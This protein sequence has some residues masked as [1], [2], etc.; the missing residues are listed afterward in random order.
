MDKLK[1]LLDGKGI[2]GKV[3]GFPPQKQI[4]IIKCNQLYKLARKFLVPSCAMKPAKVGVN[5]LAA[6]ST[7]RY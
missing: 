2:F 4:L 3:L 1:V 6:I 7:S 5:G